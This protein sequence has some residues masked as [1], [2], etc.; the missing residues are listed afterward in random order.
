MRFR[1][2]WRQV[3]VELEVPGVKKDEID[4]SL[5][6][7]ILTISWKRTK[8]DKKEEAK[9][10]RYEKSEGSFSRIFNVE[11]AEIEK[12]NASLKDGV[13]KIIIPKN[14]EAKSKKI[15]IK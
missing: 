5:K 4:L 1:G 11:G 15:E 7:D 2:T 14:E 3:S 9:S 6:N 8:E 10:S 13:L 12:I